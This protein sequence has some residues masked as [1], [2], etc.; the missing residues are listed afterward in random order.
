MCAVTWLLAAGL[1]YMP[2]VHYQASVAVSDWRNGFRQRPVRK[3]SS[4]QP[5]P[6]VGHMQ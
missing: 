5:R 2:G 6:T 4:T 3:R 1:K